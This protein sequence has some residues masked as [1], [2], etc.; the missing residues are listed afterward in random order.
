MHVLFNEYMSNLN[1]NSYL[2]TIKKVKLR[3]TLL[4]C[5]SGI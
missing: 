2:F 1:V 3:H 4:H 5:R